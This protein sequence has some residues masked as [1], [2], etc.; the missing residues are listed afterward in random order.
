MEHLRQRPGLPGWQAASLPCSTPPTVAVVWLFIPKPWFWSSA[1]CIRCKPLSTSAR[2]ASQQ[3]YVMFVPERESRDF[4]P[5]W[6]YRI[7]RSSLGGRRRRYW[8]V[9]SFPADPVRR[10]PS[11]N[12][13][14]DHGSGVIRERPCTPAKRLTAVGRCVGSLAAGA[15]RVRPLAPMTT[16]ARKRKPGRA[17][18]VAGAYRRYR[19]HVV[20]TAR[21][22]D[23]FVDG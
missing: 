2:A 9:A 6:L 21:R 20:A 18:F 8:F 5:K 3:H 10:F 17:R 22:P 16:G 1:S 7:P 23:L 12:A 4:A 19:L 13:S 11:L 14:R 15:P